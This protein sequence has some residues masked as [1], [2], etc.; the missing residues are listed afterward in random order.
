MSRARTFTKTE[1][2]DAARA[3]VETGAFIRLLPSGEIEFTPEPR[4]RK[5]AAPTP[6]D[7]LEGWLNGREAGGRA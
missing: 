5:N 6:E 7:L 3:S 4:K 1:I 2:M